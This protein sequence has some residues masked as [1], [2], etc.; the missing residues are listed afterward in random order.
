MKVIRGIL[1]ALAGLS[2]AACSNV[3]TASRNRPLETEL[4][5]VAQVQSYEVVDVKVMVPANL[6][7]SE[8]NSYY[9]IT[10]IVWRGD[11]VGDRRMQL[12]TMF[13]EAAARGAEQLHGDVPVVATVLLERFHGVT[14]RTRHSVGGVYDVL[15]TLT[16]RNAETGEIIEGPRQVRADLPAP[17]GMA[18]IRLEQSGQTEKVRMTDF[19]TMVFVNELSGGHTPI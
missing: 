16:V 2:A 17:G 19:M 15:F 8:A 18:A 10:D 9:P 4:V 12:A 13:E 6:R 1:V 3:E 11:P 14:E 5:P 7:V